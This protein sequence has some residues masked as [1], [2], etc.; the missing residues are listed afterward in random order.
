MIQIADVVGAHGVSFMVAMVSGAIGDVLARPLVRLDEGGRPR[1]AMA[2]RMSMPVAIGAVVVS[3]IYGV[4][5][6]DQTDEIMADSLP[7]PRVAVVQT[8]VPQSNKNDPAPGQEQ[9]FFQVMIDLSKQA[10]AQDP[11]L[12]LIVW[13]ETMI[14]RPLNDESIALFSKL[15]PALARY[16][17]E[18]EALAAES[19]VS[20]I[21]GAHG[22]TGWQPTGD[23]FRPAQR[24][25]SAYLVTP[26]GVTSRYDKIH[27]VPFGEYI[28]WVETIP[29]AKRW[30]LKLTPY[31]WDYTL[32]AG[33]EIVRMEVPI[34]VR[35]LGGAMDGWVAAGGEWRV[36]TPICFE[37][38]PSYLP[39]RMV[40][41]SRG[42]SK[43]VSMLVNL[44]NDGWF[45]GTH[46]PWQHEQIARFRCV[47]NRVSM[48]RS[49]NR[50]VSSFIDSAGRIVKRVEVE[51]ESVNVAGFAIASMPLD[52]RSTL[53]G[54]WGDTL[55]WISV[56]VTAGLT[57]LSGLVILTRK[58]NR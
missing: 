46:E 37:D 35:P 42:E 22:M 40:Y 50:G 11:Q 43:Q 49:V 44:T 47:E 9:Q 6:L 18:V 24:Y 4:W 8:N 15:N 12:D 25:N 17:S 51:G 16:R 21:V 13:P 53:F 27:R 7:A 23:Y 3:L 2:L 20:L 33:A 5:R 26:T 39:R 38:V 36:A 30:L 55:A 56:A 54:L 1:A 29:W 34:R 14:P 19:G 48:V 31:D 32:T 45:A 28:P 52:M 58:K 41:G 57:L 10:L